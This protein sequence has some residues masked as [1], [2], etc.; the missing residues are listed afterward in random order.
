MMRSIRAVLLPRVAL[1]RLRERSGIA[2]R[3]RG[4][5]AASLPPAC[6]WI[7]RASSPRVVLYQSSAVVNSSASAATS[8]TQSEGRSRAKVNGSA[9][10]RG[11]GSV[12]TSS[13]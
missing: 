12:S 7:W 11:A 6:S 2:A 4:A 5:L 9:S 10:G 3:P 13:G 1:L 8:T